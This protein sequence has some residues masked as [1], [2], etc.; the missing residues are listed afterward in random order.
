[1]SRTE[2][3]RPRGVVE[4]SDPDV[5]LHL[6]EDDVDEPE[7]SVVVQAADE[8]LTVGKGRAAYNPSAVVEAG[9]P[10]PLAERGY[11]GDAG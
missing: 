11:D 4:G 7:I 9:N 3:A 8:E 2:I 1:L 6:P 10:S 5:V